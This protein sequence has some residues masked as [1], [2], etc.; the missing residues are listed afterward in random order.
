MGSKTVP[1]VRSESAALRPCSPRDVPGLLGLW[2]VVSGQQAGGKTSSK[3]YVCSGVE[4]YSSMLIGECSFQHRIPGQST[5]FATAGG[6]LRDVTVVCSLPSCDVDSNPALTFYHHLWF[7]CVLTTRKTTE[8]QSKTS[9]KI[10]PSLGAAP[11]HGVQ[12]MG[13]PLSVTLER[14]QP[15]RN[16][17]PAPN[18]PSPLWSAGIC[19]GLVFLW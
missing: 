11:A 16:K 13:Q 18:S 6:R 9:Q 3:P 8:P 5:I 10:R 15:H 4:F 19:H 1:P 14:S 2:A 7:S 12:A 17:T